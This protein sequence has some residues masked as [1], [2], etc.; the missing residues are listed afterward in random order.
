MKFIKKWSVD[1]GILV[2]IK[3]NKFHKSIDEKLG[4][5]RLISGNYYCFKV[6]ELKEELKKE[7]D[8]EIKSALDV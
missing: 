5:A 7:S 2:Y 1:N 4:Q 6:K 8:S 3:K